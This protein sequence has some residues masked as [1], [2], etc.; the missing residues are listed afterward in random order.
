MRVYKDVM[1][2]YKGIKI[3]IIVYKRH[4]QYLQKVL[5]ISIKIYL[6]VCVTNITGIIVNIK[7]H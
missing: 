5:K 1:M 7:N 2:A 3:I 6:F 4:L